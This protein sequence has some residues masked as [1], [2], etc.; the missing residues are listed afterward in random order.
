[1]A[2]II[3]AIITTLSIVLGNIMKEKTMTQID[4]LARE[5]ANKAGN[6]IETMVT[7]STSIADSIETLIDGNVSDTQ[8]IAIAQ[9]NLKKALDDDRIFGTYIALEPNGILDNTPNG[10]SYYF[11]KNGNVIEFEDNIEDYE[12]Y[13]SQDYYIGS[14]DTKSTY[15][16]DP[17]EYTLQ[18]GD[19][20]LLMTLSVPLYDSTSRFMGVVNCDVLVPTID[21]IDY[22]MGGFK[23]AYS[24]I[25]NNNGIYL[26]HSADNERAG[27]AYWLVY[28]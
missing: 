9:S 26:A 28:H 24:Y 14:R 1:M 11:F 20:V 13:S 2:V 21:E 5:N 25:L 16:T 6:Y 15:F 10:A 19:N 22:D 27:A 8:F 17:Y 18:S 3:I 4:L 7:K 23:T 12:I